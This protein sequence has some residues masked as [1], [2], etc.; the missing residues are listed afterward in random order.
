MQRTSQDYVRKC[1]QCQ[2]YARH[3]LG[4]GVVE[5]TFQPLAICSVGLGYSGTISPSYGE[6]KVASYRDGLLYQVGGS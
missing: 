2:R 3:Q 5:P 6:S 1:N 4:G